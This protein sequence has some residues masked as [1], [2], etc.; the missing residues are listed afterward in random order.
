MP[1]IT[2]EGK[3]LVVNGKLAASLNCCCDANNWLYLPCTDPSGAGECSGVPCDIEISGA[4]VSNANGVYVFQNWFSETGPDGTC[5]GYYTNGNGWEIQPRFAVNPS[6]GYFVREV[7]GGGAT[8]Y[9]S[10]ELDMDGLPINFYTVVGDPTPPNDAT[11]AP[12]PSP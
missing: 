5:L 4:G 10:D 2:Y 8:I 9:A 1:L 3:L 12:E 6:G 7:G 11:C